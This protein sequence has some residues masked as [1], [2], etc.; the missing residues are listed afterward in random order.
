MRPA[1]T[2]SKTNANTEALD[3]MPN[4]GQTM[5]LSHIQCSESI[6][7]HGFVLLLSRSMSS[8]IS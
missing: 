7:V 1:M 3:F 5:L 8:M 2:H 4:M 6:D